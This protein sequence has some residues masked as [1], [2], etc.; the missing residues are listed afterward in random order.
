MED[1]NIPNNG[2][3]TKP[4]SRRTRTK[5]AK[6]TPNTPSAV[7]SVIAFLAD[8]TEVPSNL[9]NIALFISSVTTTS[10]VLATGGHDVGQLPTSYLITPPSA[11]VMWLLASYSIL[12]WLH[13]FYERNKAE[14]RF[15]P[16]FW[17]FLVDD[18]IFRF[19]FP[20][21]SFFLFVLGILLI[22]IVGY[23]DYYFD[24]KNQILILVL[25]ALTFVIGFLIYWYYSALKESID[26]ERD[27]IEFQEHMEKEWSSV[28]ERISKLLAERYQWLE[29]SNFKDLALT[30][31]IDPLLFILAFAR[32]AAKHSDET[33]YA[34]LYEKK[35]GY[36][37]YID[38]PV[39]IS[40]K[41]LDTEKYFY[42]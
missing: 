41:N 20:L 15:L 26:L 38:H 31:G 11:F 28:E 34:H 18:I 3:S 7:S 37:P 33:V 32:Y 13:S 16:R 9:I 19:R 5:K 39:L 30:W 10:V 27:G 14:K 21:R 4:K 24:A 36:K 8:L 35:W 40:L 22:W 17:M 42:K 29:F 25:M 2:A 6:A 12:A 23:T 1:A